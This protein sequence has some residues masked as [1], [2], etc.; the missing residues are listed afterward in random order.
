MPPDTTKLVNHI[1]LTATNSPYVSLT[2]SYGVAEHYAMFCG[3]SVPTISMPAFVY[4][5]TIPDPLPPGVNLKLIDPV[6]E[7]ALHLPEPTSSF[8]YQHDGSPDFLL[9][10][11]DPARMASYLTA[12]CPQP[13]PHSGTPR[14]PNLTPELETLLRALR[15]AEILAIGGIPYTYVSARYDVY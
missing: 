14:S 2:R 9:G 11:V 3:L 8:S 10:V 15:D 1:R 7:I 5:I 4:E 12:V 13:P 6:K